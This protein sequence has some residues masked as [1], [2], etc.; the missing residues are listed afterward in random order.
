MSS[1]YELERIKQ[2]LERIALV[3]PQVRFSLYDTTKGSTIL[4]TR[5]LRTLRASFEQLFGSVDGLC[6]VEHCAGP[7]TFRDVNKRSVKAKELRKFINESYLSLSLRTVSALTTIEDHLDAANGSAVTSIQDAD[8][9]TIFNKYAVFLLDISCPPSAYDVTLDPTKTLVEFKGTASMLCEAWAGESLARAPQPDNQESEHFY[10]TREA[11]LIE[12]TTADP[13]VTT[14]KVDHQ[15]ASTRIALHLSSH[16]LQRKPFLGKAEASILST[17]CTHDRGTQL[18][19]SKDVLKKMR[20]INQVDTKFILAKEGD[21][22]YILDQHAVDERI[23]L[24]KLE[25]YS[26]SRTQVL[27]RAVPAVDGVPL[28]NVDNLREFVTQLEATNG[29]AATKPRSIVR[30]LQSKA[31]RGALMFGDRLSREDCQAL[32]DRVSACALPF[33]CAHGKIAAQAH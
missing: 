26:G 2:T 14:R 5:Q 27:V 21:M 9:K 32:I 11:A 23:G 7:Y 25:W 12:E 8:A 28:T 18:A 1:G 15:S 13:E 10:G 17:D 33:Q 29:S 24:E 16:A 20:V 22:L 3:H 30:L 19:V 6:E 31:C 4:H